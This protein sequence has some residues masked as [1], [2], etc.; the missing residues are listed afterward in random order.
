MVARLGG[1]EFAML[2]PGAV[3][4]SELESLVARLRAAL[5][6]P[7][8]VDGQ[9]LQLRAS[10][11]VACAPQDGLAIDELLN[12]ADIAMYAAKYAGGD[13]AAY[14]DSDL[15]DRGRRRAAIEQAL[16]GAL[17]RG[18]LTLAYQPQVLT[19]DWQVCGF[20]AL[21]RWTDPELG[22]LPPA[23]FVPV[24]EAAGL[25]PDIGN[26]VLAQ[27][28]R[29]A[30]TWPDALRVSVNV[31]ATQLA[32]GDLVAQVRSA[33]A[34]AQLPA[35][36]L[37][38]EITESTLIADADAAIDTLRAL[39]AMGCRTALDDFGTGYS[40]LGYLRR[41][42]F[43]VLKIDRSFVRDLVRDA[44][45]RVLVDTILAM[46]R[47][48]RMTTVAEGVETE[49]EARLLRE[50]GCGV[51]QGFLLSRPLPAADLAPWRVAWRQTARRLLSV[52]EFAD[53]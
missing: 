4:R 43:D 10:I 45:A 27:A 31:S 21:L 1:D 49:A 12:N 5:A 47:A 52:E 20:E 35:Q 8:L 30:A 32:A 42:P 22:P 11:G 48:L 26:W 6:E 17:A 9:A 41:F 18:D 36:R 51:V 19:D 50:R 7:C 44:E 15:A 14:F 46:A 25:M 29:S 2:L 33:L 16:R 37:E 23:E 40:A 24:A 3:A 34:A 13:R 39:R 28:C 53:G 38:L